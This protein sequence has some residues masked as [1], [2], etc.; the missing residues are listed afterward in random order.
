MSYQLLTVLYHT[1]SL[2]L[3]LVMHL[4]AEIIPYQRTCSSCFSSAVKF[5]TFSSM[6][7]FVYLVG[8]SCYEVSIPV[9][10]FP[11]CWFFHPI[12]LF[13]PGIPQAE[14]HSTW[15]DAPE[16]RGQRVISDAQ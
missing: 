5:F 3:T 10:S 16:K 8:F 2:K 4:S 12:L 13:S 11:H 7:L 14:K 1:H 9:P 6:G 15:L